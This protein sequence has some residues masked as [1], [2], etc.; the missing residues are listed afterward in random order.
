M[1]ECPKQSHK[2][3]F[4]EVVPVHGQNHQNFPLRIVLIENHH[5]RY[6]FQGNNQKKHQEGQNLP[7]L[8]FSVTKGNLIRLKR[9]QDRY[10]V[11][12][13]YICAFV[14]FV[15]TVFLGVWC[16]CPED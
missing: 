12:R 3:L 8:V 5:R 11:E 6:N 9:K 16:N 2:R 1:V 14:H 15:E 4:V 7:K 10:F 13:F